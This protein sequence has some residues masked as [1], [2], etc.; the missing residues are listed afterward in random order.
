ME[1]YVKET[2]HV[3]DYNENIKQ[4]IFN[5]DDHMTAGYA[6]NITITEAN[7]GYSDLKFEMPNTIINNNG[8]KIK[9]PFLSLLVP[10][11]KLRYERQ[12]YY[13]GEQPITVCE[14][15]GYGDTTTYVDRTYSNVYPDNIIEDYIMDYIVQPIDKKRDVLKISTSFTAMDYPRFNLSKKRVGLTINQDT[16]TRDEW[17]IFQNKPLDKPGTIKYTQWTEDLSRIAGKLDIPLEWDPAH[18]V[19]YPLGKEQIRTLMQTASV[20]PYGLL[21][22]AFYWPITSTARFKGILYKEGGYLVLQLYDFYDQTTVGIDPNLYIDRYSWDWTQLYQVD[23]YLC[24]NNALNYLYHILEGT[25]WSVALRQDGTP[26]VDIVKT[27][28]HNP[29]GSVESTELVDLQSNINISSGNCYNAITAVCKELQ[30]YSVFDCIN[31]TVALRQFS[32]KNYGLVYALGN[33]IKDNTIKNDGE[34]VITKLYCT[35]G[36]DYD[37]DANINIGTATRDYTKNFTGFYN[38]VNSLPTTEI[39]GYYAIVDD[40]ISNDALRKSEYAY[41][42]VDG[43]MTIVKTYSSIEQIHDL[44]VPEYWNAGPNRQVYYWDGSDWNLAT[45]LDTGL[46]EFTINGNTVIVDPITG[47]TGEWTPNDDMY[48]TG[49]SP[50]GTNY[51]LNLWWSYKNNW[52]TKEQILELYQY[53]QQI[54]DL[55]LAFA[56]KYIKDYREAREIYNTAM[57]EY[58]IAQDGFES[59]LHKMENKY[60]NVDLKYSEGYTYAFHKAPIDTYI[61][62]NRDLG[63]NTHYMKLFHCYNHSCQETRGLTP[64]NGNAPADLATCPVCGG[65][66]VSNEE[67]YVPTFDDYSF[68]YDHDIYPYTTD[69]TKYNEKSYRYSPHLKGDFLSMVISMD[70]LDNTQ[71]DVWTIGDY[72]EAISLIKEIPFKE[73]TVVTLDGYDYKLKGV[74]VRSTSGKIEVW[75]ADINNYLD[76]YGKMLDDLR[77]MLTAQQRIEE[78]DELYDSWKEQVDGLHAT[79]QEHFGDYLIEGNY[80]N[81]EQPYIGLLFNEGKEASNKYSVPEIT[82]SLNVVDSSGLIEYR[83]PSITR[84]HCNECD[85]VSYDEISTCPRCGNTIITVEHDVY[86]D[87]VKMLH[88]VGQII[89]KAGDYVTVYDEPMGMYGVPALITGITRYLDSPINNKIDLNTSYTDEEELVGNIIT[90]TNTVLNNA[91]IYARTAILRSDGTIDPNSITETLNNNTNNIAIVGTSGNMLLDSTGMRVTNSANPSKAMKYSGNGIYYTN[92]FSTDSNEA[93]IWERI[94]SDEGIN[95]NYIRSGSIDTNR[96]TILSGQY[97]KVVLDQY[98]LSV[99]NISS[100]LSHVTEFD[101]A[102]A[103]TDVNYSKNWSTTNNIASFVG[104]DTNND[105]LIYTKG[106]LV[107]EEGS[108][109]AN[110]ITDNKGFYHLNG[111]SKDLWL[112]PTGISGT[113]NNTTKNYAFYAN[114]NFGVDTSGNLYANNAHIRGQIIISDSNSQINTGT[115]GGWTASSTGLTNGANPSLVLSPAGGAITGTVNNSGSRSDWGIY[116]N[117]TFGVTTGGTLYATG[118]HVAGDITANSL[119]L[120]SNATVPYNKISGTPDLTIYVAK[121]GRIGS[122]PAAGTTGFIVSSEGLLQASNATIY[123]TIYSSAGLIAGWN[124]QSNYLGV[125]NNS[126]EGSGSASNYFMSPSGLYNYWSHDTNRHSWLLYF[127]DKFGIDTT[128]KLYCNGAVIRGNLNAGD[129]SEGTIAAARIAANSITASK[130]NVDKLSSVNSNTGDLTISGT[131]TAQKNG[132]DALKL[133]GDGIQ[134]GNSAGYVRVYGKDGYSEDWHNGQTFHMAVVRDVDA[135]VILQKITF[136]FVKGI[137]VGWKDGAQ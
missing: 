72:E 33:N 111:Q 130:L 117:G 16:L 123:G 24:P 85:Y 126:G 124:I 15:E 62:Y 22:S 53:E 132:V 6:Y 40:S 29:R 95:A 39:E 59:T 104:V 45:K 23:S 88:S 75:N 66:D 79:I 51:I 56:D 96:L 2:L 120:G 37:G 60:Y 91:D 97:G 13:V 108:N 69:M 127:K 101:Q 93:V 57:N 19:E 109:I 67:I 94:L 20:W 119:T 38:N 107:A 64:I 115:V 63:K 17:T 99:K 9:N 125:W 31:R 135:A 7:T 4:T 12:V 103:K 58:D 128:G 86:N 61:A 116:M 43:K 90:A 42:E 106:F 92:N 54:N 21:A 98:G 78:L 50:Y 73:A 55:N 3:L 136:Y 41:Q 1:V 74:Y 34:R 110:W 84:Y 71:Q 52:I 83:E 76:N 114:G 102:L 10:L 49:R 46:W 5:S 47:T 65:H 100:E 113:V 25:N 82:Y 18:A 8:E 35:G 77:S 137:C 81:N 36:K 118:A 68:T 80:I 11:V 30:V 87:L 70:K 26:D 44:S 122:T 48:I 32:G 27:V 28:I 112:S 131:L 14:P 133:N 121:D 134:L 89:P 129:L 105:P